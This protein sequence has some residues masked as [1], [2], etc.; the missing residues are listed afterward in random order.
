VVYY[1]LYNQLKWPR[2][3]T[4]ET[5]NIKLKYESNSSWQENNN[6]NNNNNNNKKAANY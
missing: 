2:P 6:N 4:V 1:Y 5:V 3:C